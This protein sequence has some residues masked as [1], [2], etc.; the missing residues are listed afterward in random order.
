MVSIYIC[1]QVIAGKV[2]N[3][4]LI[5]DDPAGNSYLQVGI[6]IGNYQLL[7][8]VEQSIKICRRQ[9]AQLFADAES[10]GK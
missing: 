5:L 1:F 4:H 10:K 2:M 9:E 8:E 6:I 7:D 3:I